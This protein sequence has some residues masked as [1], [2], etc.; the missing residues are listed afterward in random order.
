MR[1]DLLPAYE[2]DFSPGL[3]VPTGQVWRRMHAVGANDVV[4]DTFGYRFDDRFLHRTLGTVLS[5][6]I[7]DML[8]SAIAAF[9]ADR[10]ALRCIKGSRQWHRDITIRI[11]VRQP[12][13]WLD[14]RFGKELAGFLTYLTDDSWSVEFVPRS[15]ASRRSE[16]DAALFTPLGRPAAVSVLHSGGL[17]SCLGIVSAAQSYRRQVIVAVSA[18]SHSHQRIVQSRVLD[19]LRRMLPAEIVWA[20]IP[21]NLRGVPRREQ[22]S[23]QRTRG[24]LYLTAGAIGAI[25]AGAHVLEVSETGIGAINLPCAPEQLGTHTTRS[26][27]PLTLAR[28]ERLLTLFLGLPFT[29]VNTSIWKTKT[30][31]CRASINQ[32]G[33]DLHHLLVAMQATVSCDR[34]PWVGLREACGS[35]TSCLFRRMSLHAASLAGIEVAGPRRYAFDPKSFE[36]NWA[37]HDH[38]PIYALRSHVERLHA[39]MEAEHPYMA[40]VQE[41]PALT[42]LYQ[43][44]EHLQLSDGELEAHIVRLFRAFVTEWRE[45]EQAIRW[46]ASHAQQSVV[47]IDQAVAAAI[48]S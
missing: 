32:A 45:F 19:S 6:A 36:A 38:V 41:F 15:A 21:L 37:A 42:R 12:K 5:P 35:C 27:H 40:L 23:S 46:P 4:D 43:A 16:Q 8:D 48:A 34:F 39:A 2:F 1:S 10:V 18:V 30:E 22:E 9:V 3:T 47:P 24:L 31:S 44:A 28:F 17:D 25:L 29:V 20:R 11:P 33:S 26:M 13:L 7:A 14:D